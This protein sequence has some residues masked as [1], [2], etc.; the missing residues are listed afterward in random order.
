VTPDD[1]DL[2]GHM[3]KPSEAGFELVRSAN[4]GDDPVSGALV[5]ELRESGDVKCYW[6]MMTPADLALVLV[7]L[8]GEI[9][10]VVRGLDED[11]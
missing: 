11:E 10:D 1:I 8:N 9:Q 6:S 4:K 3:E 5:V 7:C 2:V